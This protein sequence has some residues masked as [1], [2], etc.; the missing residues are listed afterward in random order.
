M[1]MLQSPGV[2][3]PPARGAP[4]SLALA[5]CPPQSEMDARQQKTRRRHQGEA[6]ESEEKVATL[7]VLLKNPDTTVATYV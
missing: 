3:H 6:A 7:D 5:V 1:S 4:P 2:S